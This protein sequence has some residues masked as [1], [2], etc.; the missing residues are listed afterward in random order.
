MKANGYTKFFLSVNSRNYDA[1]KFYE[2]MGGMKIYQDEQSIK[3]KY[4]I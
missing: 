2:A 3:Y 4:I 1:Q